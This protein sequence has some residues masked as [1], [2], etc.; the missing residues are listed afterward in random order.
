MDFV[1]N[2][3]FTLVNVGLVK[4][5]CTRNDILILFWNGVGC[6]VGSRQRPQFSCFSVISLRRCGCNGPPY[7]Q[8]LKK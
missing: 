2:E 3:Q 1:F 6:L 7:G 5:T 8:L 4:L